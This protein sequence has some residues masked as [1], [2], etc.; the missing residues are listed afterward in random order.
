MK[1]V[2]CLMFCLFIISMSF[3][4][5]RNKDFKMVDHTVQADETVLKIS[6]IYQV[7]PSEVYRNNRKALDGVSTG[8]VLQIPVPKNRDVKEINTN[9][10]KETV[11]KSVEVKEKVKKKKEIEEVSKTEVTNSLKT[12]E[13]RVIQGETLYGLAR[14]Y[15]VSVNDINEENKLLLSDGLKIGQIIVIPTK[16]NI[17]SNEVVHSVE[18]ETEEIVVSKPVEVE[19]T[20]VEKKEEIISEPFATNSST[21]IQHRVVQGET[22]YGLARKY[23]VSVNDI[24]DENKQ[25]LS[26]G[27][28]I[29][30][31]I[32]IPTIGN[33]VSNEVVHST[34]RESIIKHKVEPKETLYGLSKRYNVSVEDILSQ[35]K[36]VKEKGLQIGQTITI[37]TN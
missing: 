36:E 22:L 3:S 8:M 35:N 4:Q 24:N 27:L 2:F 25:L 23:D 33:T 32:V 1:N 30:Q 18:K 26:D 19:E 11:N 17:V 28:K 13:H 9:E 29:G 14:K 31:I 12:L 5:S 37:K 7:D 15:D 21:F 6:K 34:N 16:G 10:I 20:I